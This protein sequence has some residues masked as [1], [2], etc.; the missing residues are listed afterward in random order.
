MYHEDEIKIAKEIIIAQ[1]AAY[2]GHY[3]SAD[4]IAKNI[5]IVFK[6]VVELTKG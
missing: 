2:Q 4:D 5:E 6:K 3:V 1:L